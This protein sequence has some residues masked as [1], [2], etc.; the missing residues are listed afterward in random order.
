MKKVISLLLILFIA[1]LPSAAL[2]ADSSVCFIATNNNLL[3]LTSQAISQG[4]QYYVPADI[5]AQFRIY[6]S[7]HSSSETAELSSGSKQFF[8]NM[9]TGETYDSENSYYSTS[10][11]MRGSTV[12]VPVDFVCRQ[13]GLSWSYIRGSGYGDVCRITDSSEVLT[14]ELFMRAARP[15]IQG[16]YEE[17]INSGL[18]P[19][20]ENDDVSGADSVIFLSFQ[21]LPSDNALS[22]LE[23]YGIKATFFLS[24][25][26]IE[27]SPGTV[28]RIVGEGHNVGALCSANPEREFEE[29]SD[30]LGLAAHTT[31]IMI[32]AS[33]RDYNPVCETYADENGLLFCSYTIDGVRSGLGLTV[34]DLTNAFANGRPQIAYLRIQCCTL[35]DSNLTGII[36]TLRNGSVVLAACESTEP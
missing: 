24:A 7:Y 5:F 13:F 10:A 25:G 34:S 1:L 27:S 14:D 15:L 20:G 30:A 17:Y 6:S 35:T 29:F 31:T 12:Y 28:R 19:G 26:D 3:P 23:A 21:G 11:V 4:G 9:S 8:F 2:A 33:A 22:L 16:R 18:Y 32:A 36:N